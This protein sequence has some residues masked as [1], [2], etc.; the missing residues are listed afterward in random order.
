[1]VERGVIRF[2]ITLN[3]SIFC[4]TR[5]IGNKAYRLDTGLWA[6]LIRRQNA[7]AKRIQKAF[8]GFG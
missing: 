2:P 3:P 1:M 6:V 4:R 7:E 5:G 8:T